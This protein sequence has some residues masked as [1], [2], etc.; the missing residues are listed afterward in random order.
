MKRFISSLIFL[1]ALLIVTIVL[2][3][4]KAGKPKMVLVEET[5]DAGVVYRTGAKVEHAFVIRNA[6]TAPLRILRATPG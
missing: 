5:Y 4:A 3:Q 2:A 1:C 6:G